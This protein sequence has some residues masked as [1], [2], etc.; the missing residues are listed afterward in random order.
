MKATLMS[1][2]LTAAVT[3]SS[4]ADLLPRPTGPLTPATL[5][6]EEQFQW[7]TEKTRQIIAVARVQ[8]DDAP[9]TPIYSHD[10]VGRSAKSPDRSTYHPGT[11]IYSPGGYGK[12]CW[13]RDCYYII[14]GAPQFVPP[15]EIR[16]IIRLLLHWQ[17]PDGMVPKHFSGGGGDFVCWGPP[18]ESDSAQFAVQLG[19]EYYRRSGDKKFV[20]ETVP[21]LKRA[22]DSMPRDEQGLSWIDPA[23]PHTAYGF[24]DQIFK[25]GAELFSS[26]LYWEAS[27]KLA[28]MATVVGEKEIAQEMTARADLIEKNLSTLWDEKAGMYLAASQDCRQIDIWGSAYAVYIGFPDQKKSDRI[29]RYLVENYSKIVYEGQVRH[30]PGGEYWQ[31][32]SQPIPRDTY[33]NGAYWGTATGWVAYA[34]AKIDPALASSML[35]DMIDYYRRYDAFECVNDKGHQKISGYGASVSNPLDAIRRMRAEK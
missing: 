30:L 15:E 22:M 29:S 14:H 28:E 33:Q 27:R 2:I 6:T 12:R 20:A 10:A 8:L 11:W 5:V 1:I 35:G 18:P 7:L 26:L 13:P 9:A 19:D 25:T 21:A 32:T 17:R 23:A 3:A 34:I 16:G 24:T 4:G 31:K